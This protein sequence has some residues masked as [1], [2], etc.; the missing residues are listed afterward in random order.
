MIGRAQ[1][2]GPRHGPIRISRQSSR[3]RP[4]RAVALLRDKG[5]TLP[6]FAELADPTRIPDV[7]G[8]AG[9]GRPR[10]PAPAQSVSRALVQRRRA[11]R[12]AF[13]VPG[14]IELPEALTGVKARIVVLLGRAVPDDPRAQG[15]GRL[16]LP[17]AAPGVG[18]LRSDAAARGVAVDRKLLPRRRRHLAHPGLPRRRRAA[19][20]HEPGALRLAGRM[21]DAP[22]DIVRTPGTESNVKEIYDKCAELARDRSQRD[23]Q[24]VQRVR[25]L[26]GALALH[27]RRRSSSVFDAASKARREPSACGLRLGQRLGR[28]AGGRRLPEGRGTAPRSPWS[29]PSSA[30]RCSTTAT[31][32][33]TS[34]ASATSTCR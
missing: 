11:H 10:R 33:T 34:R 32:S 19:R 28:H 31:A 30:R 9:Q 1:K 4:A 7:R 14:H 26:P 24:P 22:E 21:G 15:A 5:V 18:P 25:Q 6:T 27:R 20:R 23:R 12:P 3:A 17:G 16:C 8:R 2:K 13:R 29:R